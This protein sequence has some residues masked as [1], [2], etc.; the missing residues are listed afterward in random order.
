MQETPDSPEA[1]A[2]IPTLALA[3]LPRRNK[4]IP[5]EVTLKP[6]RQ[7]L[8]HELFTNGVVYLDVGFDLHRSSGRP[9]SLCAAV[10]PR[11]AGDR[12]RQAGFRAPV[13]ADRP[14]DRRHP[15]PGLDFD[16]ARRADLRSLVLPARQGAP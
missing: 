8:Y 2:T 9:P 15:A 6:T 1:L 11:A 10:R 4:L 13:A 5:I 7:V 3:D 12:R 14:R 16:G